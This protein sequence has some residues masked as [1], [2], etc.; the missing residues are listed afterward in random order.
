MYHDPVLL[1]ESIEGLNIQRDGIYLDATFG[2]GGHSKKI[3]E[4]LGNN[5][6]LYAFDRDPDAMAG[7]DSPRFQ[8][9]RSNFRHLK[10]FMRFYGVNALDG[11]LADLGVSSH[12]LDVPERGF[13]YRFDAELDMRMNPKTEQSASEVLN[14]YP[15]SELADIFFHY[16]EIRNA[17]QLSREIVSARQSAPIS[18]TSQ[19]VSIAERVSRGNRAK[20]LAKVFQALRIEVNE[21]LKALEEFLATSLELLKPGG[22]LVVISYHSIEDRMVKNFIKTGNAAGE[23]QKDEYGNPYRPFEAVSKSVITPDK[24]ELIRNP[25][26]R[27]A[28][29]RIAEK[30]KQSDSGK[31]Q[32]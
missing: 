21:E 19:L 12:Q 18:M 3:L 6:R 30:K 27:S 32:G 31:K 16:G 23:L 11:I 26:A 8:L 13:S 20:Y 1:E 28:K 5:G 17:R 4:N 10:R 25:R 24:E 15:E 9:I 29:M 7:W 2:G 14:Q 22:R